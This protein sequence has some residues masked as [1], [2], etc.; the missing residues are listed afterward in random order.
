LIFD[1]TVGSIKYGPELATPTYFVS[2]GY[3]MTNQ[4]QI[5]CLG[6]TI[7]P[8]LVPTVSELPKVVEFGD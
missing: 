7:T 5:F 3:M 8:T 6:N 4:N 2:G 1:V